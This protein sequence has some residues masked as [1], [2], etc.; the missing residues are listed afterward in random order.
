[1]KLTIAATKSLPSRARRMNETTLLSLSLQS[2][3]WKP[4]GSKSTS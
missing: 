1:M 4:A 3:H 2:I